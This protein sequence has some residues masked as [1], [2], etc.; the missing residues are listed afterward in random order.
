M[1]RLISLFGICCLLAL[2]LLSCAPKESEPENLVEDTVD[3]QLTG[4]SKVDSL[5]PILKP[6]P[7]ARFY[8]PLRQDSV[9][10]EER[11]VL[12]PSAVVREG[13]VYL[14]YRA[15]D[16]MGTSRI[17]LA[18]SEDALATLL[19][20]DVVEVTPRAPVKKFCTSRSSL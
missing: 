12:N 3:W 11:N 8:C 1:S 5:N 13:R 15:Q 9:R 19:G 14:F 6:S 16:S 2:A 4:F 18:T 7:D 20:E 17:G 10:W